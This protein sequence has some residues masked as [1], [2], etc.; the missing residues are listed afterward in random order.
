MTPS[1]SRSAPSA[2]SWSSLQINWDKVDFLSAIVWLLIMVFF[3]IGIH[4]AV[5]KVDVANVFG[6]MGSFIM[7][8]LLGRRL[9]RKPRS[10]R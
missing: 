6:T 2:K 5:Q 7:I 10:K 4:D 9:L 1:V 3:Y 8:F